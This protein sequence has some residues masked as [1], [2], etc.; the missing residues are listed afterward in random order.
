[1]SLS[2]VVPVGFTLALLWAFPTLAG[3]VELRVETVLA[4]N[5]PVAAPSPEKGFAGN[6]NPE[7]KAQLTRAFSYSSYQLVQGVSK[8]VQWGKREDFSLPGGRL[9]QIAP[10]EYANHRIALQIMLMEGSN[11]SPFMNAALW[12]PNNGTMFYG[13]RR[14]QDSVLIIRI[15]AAVKE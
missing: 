15:G 9:L 3:E 1:M 10:R 13:G 5:S 11:P 12:L 4:T 7:L 2:R 6:F 14:Y 8:K